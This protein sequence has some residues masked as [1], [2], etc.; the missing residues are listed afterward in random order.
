MT[1]FDLSTLPHPSS[2]RIAVH[3]RP[4]AERAL[5]QGHPW[6]FEESIQRQNREGQAGDLA[7]IFD[8][9]NRFL[10]IG[11]YDPHSVIR[12][13]CLQHNTQA[14]INAD[15]FADRLQAAADLRR[16][17]SESAHT[18][19]YRLIHGENDGFPGLVI[20]RYGETLV[21]KL[22]S[23]A[24][25]PHL[26]AILPA[27]ATIQPAERIVLRLSRLL[28][29]EPDDLHGLHDGQ[30]LHG[31]DDQ[32]LA[33]FMENGLHFA[34]DVIH[35]HKTGFFFDHRDNRQRVGQ[36]ARGRKVLDIFAYTGGFSLYAANGGAKEVLSV[37]I[38]A[39]A[40]KA[41]EH[42]FSLN[43][44]NAKISAAKHETLADDA[45]A[46]MERLINEGRTFDMVILDPPSFAKRADEV[47]RALASYAKLTELAIQLLDSGAILVMASCSSR[48]P[49]DDFY[50]TVLNTA[51]EAHKTLWVQQRNGHALDHPVG[52]AEGAYLKCLFAS[53]VD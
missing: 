17:L 24:W 42:N 46:V 11:L 10:A 22:Y 31:D 16:P 30:L 39:P 15:W 13:K 35:G 27:F 40:L 38:S 8:S 32:A 12:V 2:Q 48:V 7:V 29:N 18:T 20:D 47:E 43:A 45:F 21:M 44:E 33:H 51:Q 26:H 14:V 34:A 1:H 4:A 49:A 23:A 9:R 50:E 3:V 36:L 5:R 25:I 53:T 28:Q 52:F 37:D 6:L 19:G 41:A